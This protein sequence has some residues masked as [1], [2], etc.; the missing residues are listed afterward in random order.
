MDALAIAD[1]LCVQ[2]RTIENARGATDA[3]REAVFGDGGLIDQYE[4]ARG[5]PRGAAAAAPVEVS[6]AGVVTRSRPLV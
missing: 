1:Q 5:A 2:L 6:S 3:A 4:Q